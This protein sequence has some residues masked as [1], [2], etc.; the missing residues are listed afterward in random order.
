MVDEIR[1][2]NIFK[3]PSTNLKKTQE[4]LGE[5]EEIAAIKL[6]LLGI[7]LGDII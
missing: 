5:K 6:E 7:N 1:K 4:N 3:F 2:N